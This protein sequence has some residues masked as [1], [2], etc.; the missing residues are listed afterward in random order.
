[1]KQY[2]IGMDAHSKTCTFVVLNAKGQEVAKQQVNTTETEILKF[3]E[4]IDGEKHL[5]F[6]E[7][8]L[9]R[10]LHVV[11]KDQVDELI[12]C[13]PCF[14][15]K[16]QGPKNDYSD[17][18]HLAQQLRGGF[19]SPVF[20]EDSFLSDLRKVVTSY[21]N[22]NGDLIRAK[23]RYK[24]LFTSRGIKVP[25]TKIFYS[26]TSPIE[27]LDEAS[28]FVARRLLDQIQHITDVKCEYKIMF[29]KNMNTN[30]QIKALATIPGISAV[31][32]NIIAACVVDPRRFVNKNKY[33]SYC[34]LVRH[35][36]QS[37][38]KSYGKETI[39]GKAIL[40][41]VYMSAVNRLLEMDC[42]FKKFYDD[43]I[44]KGRDHRAA[45]K[46]VARKLAA[47]SL[48]VMKTGKPYQEQGARPV[49]TNLNLKHSGAEMIES[50]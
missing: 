6:E 11:L 48:A 50:N 31:R 15:S 26:D 30:P 41:S 13:N 28:K 8:Q 38:G 3:V 23:N 45:R 43:Q 40:K 18:F 17:A 42:G 14:I 35:D 33:W 34:M 24:S 7:C 27:Q 25:G 37:D 19:L 5:T 44:S 20:H 36:R 2:Y 1:M 12:V 4:S 9:A 22:L 10:W 46:N 16:K 29:T 32:A 47:V 39:F 49:K 21:E